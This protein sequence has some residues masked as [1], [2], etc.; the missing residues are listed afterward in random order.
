MKNPAFR[1]CR[2]RG[3]GDAQ[4]AEVMITGLRDPFEALFAMQRALGSERSPIQGPRRSWI[5]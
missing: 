2:T 5:G 3:G 1:D 4:E